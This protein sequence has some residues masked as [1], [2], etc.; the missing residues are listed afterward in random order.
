M[1]ENPCRVKRSWAGHRGEDRIKYGNIDLSEAA[2][3]KAVF[4]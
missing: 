2:L 4:H 3:Q 1:A